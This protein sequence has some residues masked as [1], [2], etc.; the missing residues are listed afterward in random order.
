MTTVT[1]HIP[2]STLR[3]ETAILLYSGGSFATIHEII[4]NDGARPEIGPGTPIT[5]QAV[6]TALRGLQM[7]MNSGF[8]TENVLGIG[9]DWVVWW[10]QP[11]T[12]PIWFKSK[13]ERIGHRS[14]KVPHPGL[15]FA[16]SK[17]GGNWLVFAVKGN[18]RPTPETHLH[19]SPYFNVW[20]G[21]KICIGNVS[22][23]GETALEK[24]GAWEQA[25]FN[26]WFTHSNIHG[27]HVDYEG[28]SGQLWAD[29][30]DG[31]HECFPE[32]SLV[33][34]DM[35]VAGL[36]DDLAGRNRHASA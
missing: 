34:T 20:E 2:Q 16:V 15:I 18:Q 31:K 30:M 26:S 17:S 5:Q 33:Q 28:G 13:D 22:V 10:C 4:S 14:A 11:K 25:F 23:P 19:V 1:S 29:L 3:L 21:G 12:G 7:E 35:T 8:L 36:I 6:S 9:M 27:K 24:I 32:Q